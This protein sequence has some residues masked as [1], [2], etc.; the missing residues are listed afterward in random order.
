MT[1]QLK[2]ARKIQKLGTIKELYPNGL[3]KSDFLG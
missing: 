2:L 3:N 1:E